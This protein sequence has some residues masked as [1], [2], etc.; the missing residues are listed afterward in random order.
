MTYN[1]NLENDFT[2]EVVLYKIQSVVDLFKEKF[3]KT[4]NGKNL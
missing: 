2:S 1:I 4:I 3:N